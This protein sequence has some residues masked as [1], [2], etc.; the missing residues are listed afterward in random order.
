MPKAYIGIGSNLGNREEN[1]MKAVSLLRDNGI[2]VTKLSSM[3]ETE[4]WGLEGQ[5]K[6]INM[7]V[8]AE[9]ALSPQELL[10]LLKEIESEIGREPA[11]RWGPRI[12][13]LDIL[14][15]DALVLKTPELEI[16]HPHIAEREFVLKPLSEIAPEKIH[17]VLKKSISELLSQYPRSS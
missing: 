16:P 4:P 10:K 9:T 3:I 12:I 14:L 15:Y 13:D 8:E 2:K 17:P 5:P 7:A 11:E 6:F 1:C